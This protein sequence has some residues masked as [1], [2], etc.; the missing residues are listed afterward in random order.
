MRIVSK[1][2][3]SSMSGY[4][5]LAI[6]S[7][8]STHEKLPAEEPKDNPAKVVAPF[9]A[10]RA[11]AS[12]AEWAGHLSI[13]AKLRNSIGMEF[14][15]IPPGEFIMGSPPSELGRLDNERCRRVVLTKPF[16]IGSTEVTQSQYEAVTGSNPARFKGANNP[17]EKVSWEDADEFCRKLSAIPAE[18][19]AGRVYRLPREDEWEF[20]CRAGTETTY[21]FGNDTSL[22][23]KYVWYKA[24]SGGQTHPV[25]QKLPNSWGLYDMHG[26]IFEWCEIEP[27]G[28]HRFLDV[29][30]K[31][32]YE[33]WGQVYRG[34]AWINRE[35]RVRS[36]SRSV[37]KPT[38]RYHYMGFRVALDCPVE[39]H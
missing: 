18:Q 31:G 38:F 22:A 33:S 11:S 36:A 39:S 20:A 13:P 12:Q 35:D 2:K 1:N 5:I 19:S 23:D 10:E 17:V 6:I 8:A 29:D 30:S 21:S 32:L 9:D 4:V 37:Y 15:V 25:A 24:N 3:V 34:G 16:L 26:N 27:A 7:L 14:M 28:D